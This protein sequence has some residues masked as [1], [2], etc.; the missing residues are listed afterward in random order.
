VTP[1]PFLA[2]AA[3]QKK[4]KTVTG[5]AKELLE[6]EIKGIEDEFKSLDKKKKD[7]KRKQT[8]ARKKYSEMRSKRGK[9]DSSFAYILDKAL[10]IVGA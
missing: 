10:E 7:G 8:A 2:L 4:A 3:K 6:E 5:D 9:L 1:Y